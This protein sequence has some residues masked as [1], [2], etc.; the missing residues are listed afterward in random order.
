M[1]NSSTHYAIVRYRQETSC[2]RVMSVT[3]TTTIQRRRQC[4]FRPRVPCPLFIR[5]WLES[6]FA[7]ER[8]GSKRSR[9]DARLSVGWAEACCEEAKFAFPRRVSTPICSALERCV[10]P[11][12]KKRPA[13]GASIPSFFFSSEKRKFSFASFGSFYA[14]VD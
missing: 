3:T 13:S 8:S 9:A 2:S 1:C 10:R 6:L 14:P 7:R 5:S 11:G 4:N 12:G